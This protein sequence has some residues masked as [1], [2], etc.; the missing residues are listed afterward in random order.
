M[1]SRVIGCSIC[2]G[3]I[4]ACN[5]SHEKPSDGGIAGPEVVKRARLRRGVVGGDIGRPRAHGKQQLVSYICLTVIET[6]NK[7]GR[8]RA[9]A[10]SQSAESLA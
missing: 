9:T 1:G 10:V 3:V 8:M 6:R 7:L 5:A 2:G 4:T